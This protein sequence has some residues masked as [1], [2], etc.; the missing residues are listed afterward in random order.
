MTGSQNSILTRER[1][2]AAFA[3]TTNLSRKALDSEAV[4][5]P[6]PSIGAL[7]RCCSE[8]PLVGVRGAVLVQRSFCCAEPFRDPSNFPTWSSAGGRPQWHVEGSQNGRYHRSTT[9]ET[10]R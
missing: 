3:K 8:C 7:A 4:L 1:Q 5:E 6:R 10:E 2:V 9:A